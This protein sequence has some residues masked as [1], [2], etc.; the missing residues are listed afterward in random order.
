MFT[1]A[2]NLISGAA[3]TAQGVATGV[4]G[5]VTGSNKKSASRVAAARKAATT[6]RK[7]ADSRSASAKKA[8]ATRRKN[9]ATRSTTAKRGAKTRSQRDSR[10]SAMKDAAKGVSGRK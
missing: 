1:T 2:R 8:A 7:K 5:R 6:R 3:T 4:I 9:A 10:V